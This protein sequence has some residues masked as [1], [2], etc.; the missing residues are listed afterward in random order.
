MR[1]RTFAVDRSI[2]GARVRA[3]ALEADGD[4]RPRSVPPA[5]SVSLPAAASALKTPLGE[6][7][8]QGIWTFETDTPLQRSPK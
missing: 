7:D 4:G 5:A 2:G 6:P 8:L 3:G 1:I